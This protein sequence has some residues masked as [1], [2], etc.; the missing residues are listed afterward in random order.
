MALHWHD[1]N[2]EVLAVAREER[3]PV[4]LLLVAGWSRRSRRFQREVLEQAD[5]AAALADRVI[6]VRADKDRHPQLAALYGQGAWP[7][8][9]LLDAG[10]ALLDAGT[11]IDGPDL[12]ARVDAAV[13]TLRG[14][15]PAAAAATT[16]ADADARTRTTTDGAASATRDTGAAGAPRAAAH[17]GPRP[18]Q[19]DDA[20]LPAIEAAL[21]A[22]F[23]ERH[24][25]FG[26]GAKFPHPEALDYAILRFAGDASPRLQGVIEKTLSQMADGDLQDAVAGGFFRFT[27]GRDWTRPNTEKSLSSNAGLARNYLEAGQVMGRADF[28]TYGGRTVD[29]MLRDFFDADA[30]LFASGIEPADDYYAFDGPARRTRT[31]PRHDGRFLADANARAVSALLKAGAVLGRPGLTGTAGAVMRRLLERLWRPGR[32]MF[33][34][35]DG[36]GPKLPGRLRDQAET[37][38]ALLR[39]LQYTDERSFG[40]ALDDLL[41]LIATQFVGPDGDFADLADVSRG[42]DVRRDERAFLDGAVAAEVLLR[43]ALYTGRTELEGIARRA[44]ERHAADFLRFGWSMT[45]YGRSVELL[46]HPPLHVVVVGGEG[47]LDAGALL[48]AASAT[49]LPSRVVQRLDPVMDAGHLHRLGIPSTGRAMAYVFTALDVADVSDP[50][51]LRRALRDAGQRR[52]RQSR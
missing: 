18:P 46:L 13:T 35:D 47:D 27:E 1:W 16:D 48:D 24:G 51:S 12:L 30:G 26:T 43:G 40:P 45:A 4:L 22:N 42:R 41:R 15:S 39:L 3:R 11:W 44:L 31:P 34:F 5:V 50:P 19:L 8:L 29:A 37:A 2:D 14:E 32:G 21:L 20:L 23:D 6:A 25:G 7:S 33:H 10:G 49:Y 28:L 17:A 36:T 52:L 9:A 38:R